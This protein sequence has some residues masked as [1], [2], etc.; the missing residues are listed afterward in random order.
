[1]IDLGLYFMGYPEPAHI[2]ARTYRD[3]ISDKSFKGPWGIP[4]VAKGVTDVEA[5]AHGF[6]TFKSGQSMSFA[7]SWAEMNQ[8]EEVSVVFQGSKAGGMVRRLFGTD[9]LDNTAIDACELYTQENGRP[10]NR[11]IVVPADETLGR[12]RSA[13]N[14]IRVLEGS[15]KP[16]NSP[17]QA[18]ALMRIIDGAYK[19]AATG[20]PVA[21]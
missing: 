6:V 7:V 8:R 13:A 21:L 18:L 12:V 19:S 20:K 5:A 16:L 10:V 3:H 4:D 15:E 17:D 9:G 1:M 2:L 14:F 11:S